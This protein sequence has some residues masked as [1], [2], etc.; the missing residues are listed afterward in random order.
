MMAMLL[1][2]SK[3]LYVLPPVRPAEIQLI[4]YEIYG[5]E[6]GKDYIIDGRLN[7]ISCLMAIFSI[8][9]WL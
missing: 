8:C 9:Y 1:W 3:V 7:Q 2:P 4:K 5:N 6:A